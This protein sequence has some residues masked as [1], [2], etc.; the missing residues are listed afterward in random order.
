MDRGGRRALARTVGQG[1]ERTGDRN[2]P[3]LL[4]RLRSIVFKIRRQAPAAP[5]GESIRRMRRLARL[6][7]VIQRSRRRKA[8]G[9]ALLGL[10]AKGKCRRG[11]GTIIKRPQVGFS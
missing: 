9:S 8:N 6:M 3:Q 2:R 10:K 4:N 7:T 11:A 5:L 1:N